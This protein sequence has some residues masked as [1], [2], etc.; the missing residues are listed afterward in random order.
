MTIEPSDKEKELAEQAQRLNNELLL[1]R[2]LRVADA[3]R[4]AL[5]EEGGR[6]SIR[7]KIPTG[8]KTPNPFGGEDIEEFEE[9]KHETKTYHFHKITA[10]DWN[11]YMMK[12]AELNNETSKSLDKVDNSKIADLN[13]RIYEYLAIKYLGMNHDDY[14]RAEWDDVR[15]AVDAC[16]HMTEWQSQ[17]I[18]VEGN[19]VS[20]IKKPKPIDFKFR[21]SRL[22]LNNVADN[23]EKEEAEPTREFHTLDSPSTD[24]KSKN[25]DSSSSKSKKTFEYDEY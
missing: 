18:A 3:A 4:K 1:E 15:L 13:N 14:M 19:T 24:T 6:F 25:K 8:V 9:G 10:S 17:E 5:E 22:K 20:L 21:D 7:L 11:L 12:R 2:Q 16:N 23:E